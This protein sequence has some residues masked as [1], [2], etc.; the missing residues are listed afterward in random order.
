M[1]TTNKGKI[2]SRIGKLPKTNPLKQP[3]KPPIN[4]DICVVHAA[5]AQ[6]CRVEVSVLL[7]QQSSAEKRE[8]S[9]VW[10]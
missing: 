8:D 4:R 10:I 9:M 1:N 5:L 2:E 6:I 3:A 7:L